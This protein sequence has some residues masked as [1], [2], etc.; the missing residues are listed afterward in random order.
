MKNKQ[1][2]NKMVKETAIDLMR[3]T[4]VITKSLAT[5]VIQ[6]LKPA[7][8]EET[9]LKVD[10][11][12][13]DFMAELLLEQFN[14]A[15][16]AYSHKDRIS[17]KRLQEGIAT[18]KEVAPVV[19]SGDVVDGN[20][21]LE[22]GDNYCL[23]VIGRIAMDSFRDR[24][25]ETATTVANMIRAID[26]PELYYYIESMLPMAIENVIAGSKAHFGAIE[27]ANS[28]IDSIANS[29][30]ESIVKDKNVIQLIASDK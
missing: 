29:M 28:S 2:L 5:K 21:T 14:K 23:D 1:L 9:G 15:Y 6:S 3:N 24:R 8:E 17:E 30:A 22:R 10:T 7:I 12:Q 25:N 11:Q 18:I 16:S 26:D 4:R 13:E 27:E 20:T 19:Y